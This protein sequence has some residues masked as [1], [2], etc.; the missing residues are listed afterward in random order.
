[1]VFSS[2]TYSMKMK[3]VEKELLRLVTTVY[4]GSSIF[5]VGV[6]C[7]EFP[8]RI[9]GQLWWFTDE[10]WRNGNVVSL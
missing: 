5:V 1:M 9:L 3:K 2:N 10:P 7:R 8:G 6:L 4:C